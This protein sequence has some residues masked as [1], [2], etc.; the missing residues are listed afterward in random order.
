M[1]NLS[2]PAQRT[3]SQ[4]PSPQQRSQGSTQPHLTE[5][6]PGAVYAYLQPR[7]GWCVSNA[8]V[9]VGEDGVTLIDATATYAGAR[10]LA[11][12]VRARAELPVTRVVLTHHHGDHHFGA[13][14]FTG[15][16]VIA[17]DETREAM[18]R[19]GIDLPA[20]WP[21]AGWDEI[22]LR[23]PDL[24]FTDAFTLHAGAVRAE[25]LHHGTAHTTGDVVAW[26][27]E[28]RILFAGDL[29]WSG[30]TPFVLMGS[31]EGSLEVL[32]TLKKLDPEVVV[33][34]HGP[35]EGPEVLDRTAEYLRWIQHLAADGTA[36]G[37][38]PLETARRADLGPYAELAEPERLVGNLHRAYAE[39]EGRPRGVHLPLKDPLADMIAFNGGPLHCTV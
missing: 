12:E 1:R 10:R 24:T 23:L 9:L 25:L 28:H 2:V 5:L 15:S 6:V 29:T 16:T 39:C 18:A 17:H 37:W 32:D 35:V 27:P 13:G 22:A 34:G 33:S 8:G 36:A 21:E 38:S 4:A 31:V 14:H 26:L 19:N 20:I 3:S 30:C 11:A 7:G